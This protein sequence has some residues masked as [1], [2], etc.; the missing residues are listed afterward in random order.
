MLFSRKQSLAIF[1]AAFLAT[2]VLASPHLLLH[3][4]SGAAPAVEKENALGCEE[5]HCV[6]DDAVSMKDAVEQVRSH[7]GHIKREEQCVNYCNPKG[8]D[9]CCMVDANGMVT[10]FEVNPFSAAAQVSRP[11]Y[12]LDRNGH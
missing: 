8:Q 10:H 12:K 1:I 2:P 6:G 9:P 7:K 5:P 11:Q 4:E 3:R